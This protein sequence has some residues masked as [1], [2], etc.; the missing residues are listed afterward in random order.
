MWASE[1][2]DFCEDGV[3]SS[4]EWRVLLRLLN[5]IE[6]GVM[7][8]P[9]GGSVAACAAALTDSAAE[10]ARGWLRPVAFDPAGTR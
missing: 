2:V 4:G 8:A 1:S 5:E 6:A 10:A 3:A 7:K 9:P